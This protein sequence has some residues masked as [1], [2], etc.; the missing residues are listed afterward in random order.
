MNLG[1]HRNV[2]RC[3]VIDRRRMSSVYRL[4]AI[5]G[6]SA[7]I[8]SGRYGILVDRSFIRV[9]VLHLVGIPIISSILDH[10]S[11]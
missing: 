4:I 2:R 3:M 5:N 6:Q 9:D 7:N 1:I 8:S 10:V 11:V